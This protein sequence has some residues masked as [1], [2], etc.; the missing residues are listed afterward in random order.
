MTELATQLKAEGNRLY[1]GKD[2]KG[3]YAKYTEAIAEDKANAVLYANRAACSIGLNKS[4][5]PRKS[6]SWQD[7]MAIQ[8]QK[9]GRRFEKGWM[10]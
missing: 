3:A 7:L 5:N 10:D 6:E 8:L 9:G 4:V 2:F 1:A